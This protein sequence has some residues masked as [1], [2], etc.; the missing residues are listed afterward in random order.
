MQRFLLHTYTSIPEVYTILLLRDL[1]TKKVRH[2]HQH[3]HPHQYPNKK[4]ISVP[5]AKILIKYK[6]I[7]WTPSRKASHLPPGG[8]TYGWGTRDSLQS[9]K[10]AR[11]IKEG[12]PFLFS[13]KRR[14]FCFLRAAKVVFFFPRKRLWVTHTLDF[15]KSVF[16][17]LSKKK[18][19]KRKFFWENID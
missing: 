8:K 17:W 11:H 6:R 3:P 1:K 2:Q 9:L 13:K 14:Y 7:K 18:T 10:S 19:Q 15:E 12:R 4:I 5:T 16:F